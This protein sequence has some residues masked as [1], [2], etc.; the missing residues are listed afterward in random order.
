MQEQLE[1]FQTPKLIRLALPPEATEPRLWIRRLV[2]WAEQGGRVI[3]DIPMRPGLNIIWSPDGK[4][5]AQNE[6]EQEIGH[7][8]G[9]TLFCRLLR[10]CLGES[11]FADDVQRERI[12]RAFPEG[13]V[14]AE[15]MLDGVCWAVI[16]PLGSKRRHVAMENGDLNSIA[17]GEGAATTIEPLI[18]A[19]EQAIITPEVATLAR[20][21][22]GQ[23][24]W[25]IALAWLT[26]DQECRFDDVLDWRSTM[27]GSEAPLPA[28]GRE[29]GPRREALRALLSAIT[30]EEQDSRRTE[31]FL[32]SEVERSERRRNQIDW[33]TN[34]CFG[35]LT[36][37]LKLEN[38]V[39]PDSPLMI[40][41]FRDAVESRIGAVANLPPGNPLTLAAAHEKLTKAKESFEKLNQERNNINSQL[42]VEQK[43]LSLHKSEI[44]T[45]SY[46]AENSASQI[47]PVCE[48]PIDI[49]LATKCGL[50]HKLHNEKECRARLETKRQEIEDQD[51]KIRAL[52]VRVEEIQLE[53]PSLL[54]RVRLAEEALEAIIDVQDKRSETWQS[55]LQLKAELA[56]YMEL[57]A[58]RTQVQD[59]LT[60]SENKLAAEK[61]RLAAIQDEQRQTF[62]RI[63][64]RFSTIVSR[65]LGKKASGKVTL[66]GRGLEIVI[67]IDGDRRTAAIESLKVIAFDLACLCLSMEGKTHIPAFFVHDSPREA[68]LSIRIYTEIFRLVGELENSSDNPLFQYIVTTTTPP[69]EEFRGEPWLV[70]ELHSSPGEKRLMGV[71]L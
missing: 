60:N 59:I 27:S 65:L 53:L 52:R 18:A 9:K 14:G 62:Q 16:R 5:D 34:R 71:D 47:C 38:Q 55:A 17:A 64:F 44:P 35:R 3:R 7:G 57:L 66:A 41:V 2:I 10:Y 32:R 22:D 12:V 69:P 25:P 1:I 24:A 43:V 58:E 67:D 70:A 42:P 13:I 40:E 11:R 45:L 48:V 49:A 37:D 46:A 20:L 61:D 54:Q 30:K 31:E 23:K 29:I 4:A 19:I 36:G 8:S 39:F 26:R 50:S 6:E 56:R 51:Q 33:E 15:V 63:S 68:D 21:P 28:S